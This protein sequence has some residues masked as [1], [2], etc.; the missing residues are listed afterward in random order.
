MIIVFHS[1]VHCLLFV[2]LEHE[3]RLL[4]AGPGA[5]FSTH[6]GV[7]QIITAARAVRIREIDK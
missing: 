7:E 6:D 3:I 5:I 1:F 4:F 2:D